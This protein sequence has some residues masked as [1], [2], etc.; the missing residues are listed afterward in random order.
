MYNRGDTSRVGEVRGDAMRGRWT[1]PY[2]TVEGT[3]AE[4]DKLEGM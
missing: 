4:L 1:S 2:C 3:R